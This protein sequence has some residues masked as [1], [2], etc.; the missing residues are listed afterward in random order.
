MPDAEI[1]GQILGLGTPAS[2]LAGAL[3]WR[4]LVAADSKVGMA[5]VRRRMTEFK[6]LIDNLLE[7]V[8]GMKSQLRVALQ[9]IVDLEK[10]VEELERKNDEAAE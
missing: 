1:F 6:G 10:K 7:D 5:A 8:T 3:A 2:I 9:R 4:F